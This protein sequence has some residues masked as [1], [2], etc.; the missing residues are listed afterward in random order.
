MNHIRWG[1]NDRYFGPF[2]YAKDA[3]GYRPLALVL[4]S[5]DCEDYPGCRLRL[6]AFGRTLICALPQV[7]MPYRKKVL[8]HTWDAATVA[9][10]GRD[11]YFDYSERE[12]GISYCRSGGIGDGGFLQFF[13]GRQTTRQQHGAKM[14]MLHAVE[15]LE[16]CEAQLSTV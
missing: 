14:G 10:M 12:Y 9:R 3:K 11:W 4:G 2:T 5:G 1:D 13:L 7:I 16:A 8:A 6:S 15:Q